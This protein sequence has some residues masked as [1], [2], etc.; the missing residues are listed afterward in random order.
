MATRFLRGRLHDVRGVSRLLAFGDVQA[1]YGGL[2]AT[3]EAAGYLA[4]DGD[5]PRWTAG[6]A[7]LLFIG[8]LVDKG[9]EPSEVLLLVQAL[10]PLAEAAGGCVVLIQGNH[11]LMLL[12]ALQPP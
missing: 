1:S 3:L 4:W 9:A 11:E 7:A 10:D 12:A 2:V 6:D 5:A 8:D